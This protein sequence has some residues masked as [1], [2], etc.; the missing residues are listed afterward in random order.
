MQ[1][2]ILTLLGGGQSGVR[3]KSM[4]HS[5]RDR[6]R[7]PAFRRAIAFMSSAI[8]SEFRLV[9]TWLNSSL[10]ISLKRM[11][12]FRLRPPAKPFPGWP[13][14]TPPPI[15]LLEGHAKGLAD[16]PFAP[17]DHSIMADAG[18]PAE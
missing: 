11:L 9:M 8:S 15:D 10:K 18:D 1:G 13:G 5:A 3:R 14:P 2:R 16:R 7:I 6:D 12:D 17:A 4:I